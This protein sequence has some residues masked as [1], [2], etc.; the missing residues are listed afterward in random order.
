[1]PGADVAWAEKR[2]VLVISSP[3]QVEDVL[4]TAACCHGNQGASFPERESVLL[5]VP[6]WPHP[7]IPVS[8]QLGLG[9]NLR[10]FLGG[11]AAPYESDVAR[12]ALG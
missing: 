1:M 2:D 10:L 3:F 4:Q 5:V 8:H 7:L 11:Q 12:R 9:C 6:A